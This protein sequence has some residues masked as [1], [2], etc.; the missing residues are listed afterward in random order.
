MCRVKIWRKLW[1]IF[2]DSRWFAVNKK[3]FI[4]QV[5][6]MVTLADTQS[7]CMSKKCK[8]RGIAWLFRSYWGSNPLG[9]VR[10]GVLL[11]AKLR[12]ELTDSRRFDYSS[13]SRVLT[14]T[15]YNRV[16]ENKF[17]DQT[18]YTSRPIAVII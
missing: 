8:K 5:T 14:A 16:V 2:T 3:N 10:I 13:K 4:R 6:A 15:L 18:L 9:Y 12:F 7:I 11:L 17:H 1:S